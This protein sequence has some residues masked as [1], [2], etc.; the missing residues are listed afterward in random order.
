MIFLSV[1]A[2]GP[3]ILLASSFKLKFLYFLVKN[4]PGPNNTTFSIKLGDVEIVW[5]HCL[6]TKVASIRSDP[7]RFS[8]IK[9][10]TSSGRSEIFL[11]GFIALLS[12]LNSARLLEIVKLWQIYVKCN[13]MQA[14]LNWVTFLSLVDDIWSNFYALMFSLQKNSQ[15]SFSSIMFALIVWMWFKFCRVTLRQFPL[16]QCCQMQKTQISLYHS[17]ALSF[18]SSSTSRKIVCFRVDKLE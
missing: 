9:I 14:H 17:L 13:K 10:R 11:D 16:S 2:V 3:L 15:L 7:E 12:N 1:E 18:E 4:S 5:F 8:K 6:H